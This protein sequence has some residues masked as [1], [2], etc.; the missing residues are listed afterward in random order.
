MTGK[1]WS[2]ILSSEKGVI[3]HQQLLHERRLII[4]KSKKTIE[5]TQYPT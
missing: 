4:E 5:V 1:W 3:T 2:G